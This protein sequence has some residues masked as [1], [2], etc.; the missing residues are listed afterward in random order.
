M[1]WLTTIPFFSIFFF[2]SHLLSMTVLIGTSQNYTPPYFIDDNRLEKIQALLPIIDEMYK[3]HAQ[4]N[5]YPGY[6]YGIVL[7]GK[8]IHSGTGGYL[9]IEQKTPVTPQSMFRIAS[10]TKSFTA[11]A[12]LKLRDDGKL[13]LDDPIDKYIPEMKFQNFTEDSSIITIRDLL[14]HSAGFPTDDPWAD[15]KLDETEEQLI[16]LLKRKISFSNPVG[17]AF[18]YSNLGYTLLGSLIKKVSGLSY[19]E[20]I[21]THILEPLK[22]NA[23]WEYASIPE[24]Q[25]AHGYS[26]KEGQWVDEP[27]L[28][29]G[30]YGA[31]GGLITSIESFSR[32]VAYHQNAWPAQ[33]NS[34]STLEPKLVKRSSIREMHQPWKFIKLEPNFKYE[35]GNE[36]ALITSYGY[37]LKWLKDSFGRTFVGHRGGLPGFGSSWLFLPE[38]GI[39]IVS[40]ANFTYANTALIDLAI[41]NKII[42]EANLQPRKLPQSDILKKAQNDLV[43]V[44]PHWQNIPELL[45]AQ[46][47]FLDRSLNS[48]QNESKELFSKAGKI[49]AISEVIPENQLRGHFI[50]KCENSKLQINFAMTPENPCLIQQYQIQEIPD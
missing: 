46:N 20:F 2:L 6:A 35:G 26:L 14:M 39:G 27:L 47:F 44:I 38:Y 34:I 15:R 49:V 3:F 29:D 8:L 50:I 30:I 28:H 32:Y 21:N 11:L 10:M 12:V 25:L 22:M 19:Q 41:L 48:L 37:G 18:E 33:N 36:C 23:Y 7:D 43:S 31:M 17:I 1:N 40:F 9:D 5:G 24:N 13:R 42:V 16:E 4:K 45:F